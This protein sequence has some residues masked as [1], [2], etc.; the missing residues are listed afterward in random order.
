MVGVAR[1]DDDRV[2]L[3]AV[4]RLI[5]IAAGPFFAVGMVVELLHLVPGQAAVGRLEETLRR[6]AG[7]PDA[8]FGRMARG[9][10]EDVIDDAAFLAGCGLR[11]GG[12]FASSQALPKLVER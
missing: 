5:L 4:R 1:V 12:R 8:S 6:D 9:Q 10:P 3:A 11:V 7:V 2:E